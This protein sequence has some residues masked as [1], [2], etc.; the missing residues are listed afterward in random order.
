MITVGLRWSP[1]PCRKASYAYDR[2]SIS[3]RA[4]I[5]TDMV[6]EFMAFDKNHIDIHR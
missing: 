3:A 2:F 1:A 6:S 4:V 5:T